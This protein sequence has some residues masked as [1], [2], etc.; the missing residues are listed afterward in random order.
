MIMRLRYL[1]CTLLPAAAWLSGCQ[2][3]TEN[4][5]ADLTPDTYYQTPQELEGTIAAMYRVLCPDDAWGYI[6]GFASYFGSDD[7][8]THPASN[9]GDLRDFDRLQGDAGNGSMG[10]NQWRGTWKAIYQANAVLEVVDVVKFPSEAD[11]NGAAGQ[12]YF[13]RAMSYFYLVKTFGDLPLITGSVDVDERP[14]RQP[15]ADVYALILDDLAKAEQL[16]PESWAGQPGKANKFAAKALLSDVYLTMTGWP[17]NQ[18]NYYAQAAEKANDVILSG[19]YQLVPD[20]ADVFRTN[21][22]SESIFALQYNT[23]GGLARRSTGQFCVPQDETSLAGEEGWHDFC[24]EVTFFR[25]A[26]KCKRTDDTFLTTLKI[27]KTGTDEFEKVAWDDFE[28]TSTQHPYFKKFRYGVAAPGSTEG[29]GLNETDDRIIKM[30][31]STDKTL[32]VIRYPAVLLNYAEASAMAGG[33][34]TAAAYEAV[35]LVRRRA[36]L[37]DL[38]PGLG[39]TAFRDSVVFER[40]YEFAGEMGIRW[41]DIVRL[42]LLPQIVAERV[43]GSWQQDR[44]WENELNPTFVAPDRISTRYIAPIPQSEMERNPEWKQNPGYD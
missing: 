25:K 27:R 41:F 38:T 31:P 23:A 24:T 14:P 29:D 5:K 35:N 7:L 4:P 33:G 21:N 40:A 16:L 13:I 2:D 17:L 30:A 18:T 20:Y 36:G 28:K 26:P 34:P 12:A 6:A 10:N 15:V 1:L 39:Q 19:K 42:Q 44:Y 11:R 22:N 32:D 43:K 37:P 8:A 9:K 3:L